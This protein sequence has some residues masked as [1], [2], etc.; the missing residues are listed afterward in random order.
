MWQIGFIDEIVVL[1]KIEFGRK[2]KTLVLPTID[3]F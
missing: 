3:L 1:L 2:E